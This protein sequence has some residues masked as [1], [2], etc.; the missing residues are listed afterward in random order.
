MK[1]SIYNFI[2]STDDPEKVMIFNSLTTA[3]VE[4]GKTYVELLNVSR[5]D[6]DALPIGSKQFV[7]GLKRGGFVL[8]DHVDELKIVKFA[9]NSD[10]YDRMGLTFTIAPTLRCNFACTYCY[11]Q[12]VGNQNKRDGQHAF[13]PENVQQALLK[14]IERAAKTVNSFC[15]IWYGGE[16]LLAKEIIFDISKKIIDITEE[17]KIVY[18]AGMVTNGYLLTVD[19]DI[20]QKLKDSRI[21]TLQI[22]LDGPPE[23]HNSRRML[24]GDRGPTFDRIL[25]AIK[26]LKANEV[27]VSLRINV[28]RFNMDGALKLLDILEDNSLKD[29]S[30]H[31]GHVRADTAGCKSIESSC[32]TMEEFTLLN[33]IFLET[34][35]QRGFKTGQTPYYPRISYACGANRLNALVVDPDGDMYRCWAEIGDKAARIGNISDFK[36]RRMDERMHEI[37]WLTWEPFEYSACVECKVLPICMGGCGYRAMFANKDKQDCADW[38]YSLEHYVRVRFNREKEIKA[39]SRES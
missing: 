9:Y 21:K 20:V 24:K 25:K 28:D 13:M 37:R 5:F 17:N 38:K 35:R 32:T 36:Q 2:W 23:L 19:P 22:T 7:D 27:E 1:P 3:L 33:Q 39:A 31:L 6:Y 15:I 14:F 34:L 12:P 26:L 30:I 11:E 18:F 4:V 29:I 10:K 16:P 8:E